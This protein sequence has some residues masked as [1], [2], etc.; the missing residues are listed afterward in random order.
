MG[1]IQPCWDT[2]RSENKSIDGLM[3]TTDHIQ[4]KNPQSELLKS[5]SPPTQHL[6]SSNP[7]SPNKSIKKLKF[8]TSEPDKTISK[9]T[10]VIIIHFQN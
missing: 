1:P 9:E 6:E 3:F 4:E 7:S 10:F 5:L 8:I 2:N